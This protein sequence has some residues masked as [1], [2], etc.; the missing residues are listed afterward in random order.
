V[1]DL[2]AQVG[3]GGI[4]VTVGGQSAVTAADGTFTVSGISPGQYAVS[5][6]APAVDNLVVPPGSSTTVIVVAGGTTPLPKIIYMMDKSDVP[7]NP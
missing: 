3:L 1:Q 2:T 4:T 7:P 5:A 6:V